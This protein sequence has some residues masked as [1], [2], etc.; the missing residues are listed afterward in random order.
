MYLIE[1]GEITFF[2]IIY[3]FC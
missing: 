3:N 1:L 2:W